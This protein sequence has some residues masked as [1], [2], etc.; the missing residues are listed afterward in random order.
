MTEEVGEGQQVTPVNLALLTCLLSLSKQVLSPLCLYRI[1][2]EVGM[3]IKIDYLVAMSR[4]A[5]LFNTQ[6]SAK[7]QRFLYCQDWL[8]SPEVLGINFTS[9]SLPLLDVFFYATK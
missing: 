9:V 5:S 6:E 1:I 2:T 4:S 8:L 3:S 7:K